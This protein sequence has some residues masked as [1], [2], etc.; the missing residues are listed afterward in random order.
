M[1]RAQLE[2]APRP[3]AG[4]SSRRTGRLASFSRGVG[5]IAGGSPAFL[6]KDD[7]FSMDRVKADR[8][9]VA[10]FHVLSKPPPIEFQMY[11]S[12]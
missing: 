11:Y 6:L 5:Q 12:V 1:R 2:E 10:E 9:E 4:G 7:V 8:V 3:S